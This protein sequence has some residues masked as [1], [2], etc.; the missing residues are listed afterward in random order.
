MSESKT[1]YV[2]RSVTPGER[3]TLCEHFETDE[4]GCNGSKM[5]A[6]SSQPRL[7]DGDVLVQPTGWCQFFEAGDAGPFS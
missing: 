7:A 6:L 5:R 4:N 3:C 1:S 2:P